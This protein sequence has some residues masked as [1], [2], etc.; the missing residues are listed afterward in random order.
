MNIVFINDATYWHGNE[1]CGSK[2]VADS[3]CSRIV[4]A[5]HHLVERCRQRFNEFPS[6]ETIEYTDAFIVN[7]EGHYRQDYKE[8]D[9]SYL[10]REIAFIKKV[11][12][13]GKKVYLVNTVW[14]DMREDHRDW[15]EKLSGVSTREPQSADR[16]FVCGANQIE[17][18]PDESLFYFSISGPKH[19]R[20]GTVFGYS[21]NDPHEIPNTCTAHCFNKDWKSLVHIL[22]NSE[23]YITGQHHGVCAAI[24]A[25]C[26]FVPM[27]VN[28]HKVSSLIAWHGLHSDI[29]DNWNDALSRK[30]DP[31]SYQQVWEWFEHQTPWPIPE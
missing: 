6:E 21:Y 31:E 5:G 7:G 27:R 25:Q 16:I 13:L 9:S 2:A 14:C 12:A 29:F 8:P 4:Q 15:L 3:F 20:V 11:L 1:H 28:T 17:V 24:A 26:P 30:V 22:S 23:C 10:K 18:H 19:D